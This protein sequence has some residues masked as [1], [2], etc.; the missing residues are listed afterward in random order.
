MFRLNAL[1]GPRQ[2]RA[3]RLRHGQPR[4][5]TLERLEDRT[6]PTTFMV[7]NLNNAGAG[8]LRQAVLDAN[9]SAGADTVEF[10]PAA[11]GL[12]VLASQINV[13][14]ELAV[15]GPGPAALSVS[16]DNLTRV[17]SITRNVVVS[18]SGLTVTS[19]RA[20]EGAGIY[21]AGFLTVRNATFSNNY[22][23][24]A[25]RGGAVYN[26]HGAV[27]D[28]AD[29]TFSTNTALGEA[30]PETRLGGGKGGAIFNHGAA[31]VVNVTFTSNRALTSGGSAVQTSTTHV[32]ARGGAI[33]NGDV[34]GPSDA[35]MTIV[36]GTFTT[37]QALGGHG[38]PDVF[39]AGALGGAI[40][41]REAFLSV[42]GATFTSN[43][44]IGGNGGGGRGGG[45]GG[46][47]GIA[48]TDSAT[49]T[50][51]TF[52][53]NLA[54]GGTGGQGALLSANS[55]FGGAIS[56]VGIDTV[57]TL[58]ITRGTFRQNRAVGGAS[59]SGGIGGWGQGGALYDEAQTVTI[60]SDSLFELN[61][62][63]GIT[64][65]NGAVGGNAIGGAIAHR[66]TSATTGI[67]LLSDSV[68]Q[69][70]RA[71]AGPGG[72][73]GNDGVGSGG[74]MANDGGNNGLAYVQVVRTQI[75]G[76]RAT[77]G[78]GGLLANGGRGRGGGIATGRLHTT[79]PGTAALE[80]EE[81]YIAG[82]V[83]TS[84]VA[85]LGGA[86][87]NGQGGGLYSGT[88]LA[89][90]SM[91][92]FVVSQSMLVSNRAIGGVGASD[93][94]N[95]GHGQGGGLYADVGG[96]SL[97]ESGITNNEAT[98]G[99]AGTGGTAGQGVGGGAWLGPDTA[100]ILDALTWVYENRASTSH[101]EVF[102][103]FY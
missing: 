18:L 49:V 59:G 44:A 39:G 87:G 15:S 99:A 21:N 85:G 102:G 53:T 70:N 31:Y 29:S 6:V 1:R 71:T 67:L 9:A 20:E 103:T 100:L 56:T 14:D 78:G 8:S 55:G 72:A 4:L 41:S 58:T 46:G 86:A 26:A 80:V 95:G 7:M 97:V 45:N 79:S 30:A 34:D 50:D 90:G 64:G 23:R 91:S 5:L 54:S 73:G 77:G 43:V 75:T 101:D 83:V 51:C 37:N 96:G 33:W 98:G 65:G 82:N 27:L 42:T 32:S 3:A 93:G 22:V 89:G 47:G 84:G 94:G 57:V 28:V 60:I 36:G 63:T 17:L 12:I 92:W 2:R 13:T 24:A 52:V 11:R 25:A 48:N 88:T 68:I 38:A 62:A 66:V 76:N 35:T 69:N 74:G 40:F 61:Q 10:A 16:G 19:G 81:S